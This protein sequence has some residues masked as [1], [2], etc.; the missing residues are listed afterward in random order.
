MKAAPAKDWSAF[1]QGLPQKGVKAEEIEWS[2]IH[3]WL[4]LLPGKVGQGQLAH[5]LDGQG[6]QVCEV[7]LGGPELSGD[8][9]QANPT[10]FEGYVLPGAKD[11]RELVLMLEPRTRLDPRLA[12]RFAISPPETPAPGQA[13]EQPGGFGLTRDGEPFKPECRYPTLEAAQAA[14]VRCAQV[15]PPAFSS[16][17][18]PVNNV[19]AHVRF[20]ERVSAFCSSKSSSRTGPSRAKNAALSAHALLSKARPP[21][22]GK[23]SPR[24]CLAAGGGQG[25]ALLAQW[26]EASRNAR[27][28]LEQYRAM[29]LPE[30]VEI[31][32]GPFVTTTD[33][34]LSLSLKRLIRY[35]ADNGFDSVAFIS[36]L[37]S[38]GRYDTMK[39][40]ADH[41]EVLV[42]RRRL[43]SAGAQEWPARAR[44]V[45]DPVSG[46]AGQGAGQ[47]AGKPGHARHRGGAAQPPEAALLKRVNVLQGVYFEK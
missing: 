9:R 12:A 14:I 34:W 44:P 16:M 26:Q 27:V 42:G 46:G 47:R 19:L 23:A 15:Q 13:Q 21:A 1:I 5:Y 24:T 29:G 20:N 31:A 2:G 35:G 18:W 8:A 41:I 45:R 38:V 33:A 11:Y 22:S 7:V 28:L 30:V 32:S 10:R 43:P 39:T 6:V 37:Q 36:G 17:H 3:E 25:D 40:Q 4:A